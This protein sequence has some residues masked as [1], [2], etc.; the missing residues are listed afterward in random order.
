MNRNL[1]E[2]KFFKIILNVHQSNLNLINLIKSCKTQS[3]ELREIIG[4]LI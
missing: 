2:I 4:I 1:V 3:G